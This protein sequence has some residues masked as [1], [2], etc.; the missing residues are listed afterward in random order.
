MRPLCRAPGA[1]ARCGA[2]R[3]GPLESVAPSAG[4]ILHPR[5][6]TRGR[7]IADKYSEGKMKSTL[8]REFKDLE[9]IEKE[10]FPP[11]ASRLLWQTLFLS[12]TDGRRPMAI[13]PTPAT[14]RA[15]LLPL[16]ASTA[17]TELPGVADRA[18]KTIA[19]QFGLAL[20]GI[21]TERRKQPVLKHG[22]RSLTYM[23]EYGR[24]PGTRNEGE[25]HDPRADWLG[26]QCKFAV[27]PRAAM[28][29][30]DN[31]RKLE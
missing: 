12:E 6:H 24:Q 21:G 17:R 15:P 3:V 16:W 14:R 4:G 30:G 7:P 18:H 29:A 26:G 11:F 19:R 2:A 9:V 22:P 8:K 1:R 13:G 5:L 28:L 25:L 23:Q 27:K 10:L 20:S 31:G